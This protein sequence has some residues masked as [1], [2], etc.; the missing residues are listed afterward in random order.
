MAV[1][2]FSVSIH[3]QTNCISG[4]NENTFVNTSDPNTIE[5]DNIISVFHSSIIKEVDGNFKVWGQGIAPDRT[6]V[7]SP[8]Q[9]LPSNGYNYDGEALKVAAGSIEALSNGEEFALLTTEG[10]YF[11]GSRGNLVN[12]NIRSGNTFNHNFAPSNAIATEGVSGTNPTGLPMGVAPEDV[13]MMF[14]SY[15]TLVIVTCDGKA[16]VLS[17]TGGKNGNGFLTNNNP[18]T[19]T[20]VL[21]AENTPLENVVAVRGTRSALVALTSDG[22]LYTWGSDTYLGDGSSSSSRG[23]ATEMTLPAGVVPKMIGMTQAGVSANKQTYYLLGANGD[24]WSLGNNDHRQLGNRSTT[25]STTWTRPLKPAAQG[26]GTFDDVV[27]ISPN[28]HDGTH[29]SINV[30]TSDK[31]L[32]AWGSNSGSMIGAGTGTGYFD[33]VYMPGGLGENDAIIAVETGGHTSVAIKQCSQNYGYVGHKVNGSMGDGTT[34]SGNPTTYSFSTA[35]AIVCGAS[36]S[37]KVEDVLRICQGQLADLSDALIGQIPPDVTLEWYLDDARQFLVSNPSQVNV[38]QYYAFFIPNNTMACDNP[39]GAMVT[40]QYLEEGDPGFNQ[41]PQ[42]CFESVEDGDEFEWFYPNGAAPN[43]SIVSNSFTQPA[44]SGGYVFDV[45]KLDNSFNMKINGIPLATQE[46][47]FQNGIA[48]LPMNVRFKDG[49]YY[50]NQ[51]PDIWTI[52]GTVENPMIRVI[53]EPTG[54]IKM[55]A[56]KSSGGALE[57][58]ELYGGASFNIIDWNLTGV[59]EVEVSQLVEGITEMRG[60]GYGMNIVECVCFNPAN[61]SQAGLDTKVGITSLNRAG[62]EL[63]NWPMV[64]KSGFIALESNSKGFVVNRFSTLE[65]ENITSPQEGMMVFDTDEK[66]LKL[67]SDGKWRCFTHPTCP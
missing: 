37:P 14:G 58:L 43:G 67:Y 53:I 6:H 56:S 4:C 63:D 21:T 32:Y 22:K 55:Y 15:G 46:I 10:L 17:F 52:E 66:C 31:K 41:C 29:A 19:W 51:V 64:R 39:E 8:I 42:A 40:V 54:E 60:L 23:Y 50:S 59:N 1:L 30:I 5:Y 18:Q 45:F 3:A 28:E 26:G 38:G 65:L 34:G 35:V 12:Q 33:P 24:L 9:L 2:F 48:G 25:A 27:W 62:A 36:T 16:Y 11:W 57:E 13:K 7:Y 49:E 44:T 47:Q 20:R 61:T